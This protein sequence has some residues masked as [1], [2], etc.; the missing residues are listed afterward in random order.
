MV[1]K[2]L[3]RAASAGV[4]AGVI[5]TTAFLLALYQALWEALVSVAFVATLVG[6]CL[7]RGWARSRLYNRSAIRRRP[8]GG[9][10]DATI[11][12]WPNDGGKP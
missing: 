7:L 9:A 2:G 4:A 5:A 8:D 6:P 1:P 10:A 11:S 12:N 3:L